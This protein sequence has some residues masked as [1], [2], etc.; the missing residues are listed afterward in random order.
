MFIASWAGADTC[1]IPAREQH[2]IV[3]LNTKKF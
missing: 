2:N 3:K 1:E